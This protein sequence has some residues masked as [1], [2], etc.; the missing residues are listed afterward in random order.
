MIE[1]LLEDGLLATEEKSYTQ[2]ARRHNGSSMP[3]SLEA[4][5]APMPPSE[6]K[7]LQARNARSSF[8]RALL[9]FHSSHVSES[10]SMAQRWGKTRRRSSASECVEYPVQQGDSL[11]VHWGIALAATFELI[12]TA[13]SDKTEGE[14]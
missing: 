2:G 1:E 7:P 4:V 3:R 10:E 8:S 9:Y 5:E 13:I 6:T 11:C 12:L 14:E